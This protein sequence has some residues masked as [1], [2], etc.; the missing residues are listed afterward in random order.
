MSG[1]RGATRPRRQNNQRRM[2]PSAALNKSHD[3]S[4]PFPPISNKQFPAF[5]QR[6]PIKNQYRAYMRAKSPY[7]SHRS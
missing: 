3:V 2:I 1:Y 6:D 7:Q 5:Y 4:D